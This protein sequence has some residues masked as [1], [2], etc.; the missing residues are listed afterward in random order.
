VN[1]TKDTVIIKDYPIELNAEG[2]PFV[3]YRWEPESGLDD[4]DIPNPIAN[5]S[6]SV[7]YYVFATNEYGCESYDSTYIK[8][9]ENLRIYNVFTP[10]GDGKNDVFEIENASSFPD[11]LVEVYSRWGDRLYSSVGYS[12]DTGWDGTARG[13]DVPAGTYYFIVIPFSGAEPVT[14]NVTIIR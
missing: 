10:N 2:G 3:S 12:N 11:M 14:G 5:P 13:K 8:V 9:I 1:S 6:I 7:R 4:P